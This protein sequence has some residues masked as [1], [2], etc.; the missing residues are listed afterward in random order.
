[1][2]QCYLFSSG[3][4]TK[5]IANL[6]T[7]TDEN[8]FNKF[9]N[10]SRHIISKRKLH[11]RFRKNKPF[12]TSLTSAFAVVRHFAPVE[13]R[14]VLSKPVVPFSFS[15]SVSRTTFIF[16]Y[17][18]ITSFFIYCKIVSSVNLAINK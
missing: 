1:M 17:T 11:K 18:S 4:M 6:F 3:C 10:S 15:Y 5:N 8:C 14:L 2:S 13:E 9:K 12:F 7:L 16:V